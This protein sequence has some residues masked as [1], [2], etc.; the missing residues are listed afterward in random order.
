MKRAYV[1]LRRGEAT[2]RELTQALD[3]LRV[4]SGEDF[5]VMR[6]PDEEPQLKFSRRSET[7]RRAALDNYPRAGTQRW[8]VLHAISRH[9]DGLTRA[10]AAR[11]LALLDSSTDARVIELIRGGFIAPSNKTRRTETG[12]EA[13]VLVLT[14]KGRD[15]IW[16]H[17]D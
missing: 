14:P 2:V 5:A 9:R 15:E 11:H 1:V 13:E 7:S 3:Q 8:R 6:S 17:G 4:Q 12:S 16:A 10:E